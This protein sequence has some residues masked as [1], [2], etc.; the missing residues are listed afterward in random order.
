MSTKDLLTFCN[1]VV[2]T[3]IDEHGIGIS[4]TGIDDRSNVYPGNQI[5]DIHLGVRI[6]VAKDMHQFGNGHVC[7]PLSMSGLYQGWRSMS[8]GDLLTFR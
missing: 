3:T 4:V 8:T 1:L 6:T 2:V 7:I 5:H